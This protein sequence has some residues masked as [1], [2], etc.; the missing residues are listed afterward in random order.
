MLKKIAPQNVGAADRVVR[1]VLGLGLLALSYAGPAAPW[2]YLGVIPLLTG[3]IG[4]CP[5]YTAL[6][7]RTRGKEVAA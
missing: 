2:G 7:L 1:V 6:G 5:L 3:V 4:T